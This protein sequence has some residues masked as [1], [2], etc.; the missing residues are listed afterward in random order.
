MNRQYYPKNL[1][2]I[3]GVLLDGSIKATLPARADVASSIIVS[4]EGK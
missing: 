2:A 1:K 3:T 4:V